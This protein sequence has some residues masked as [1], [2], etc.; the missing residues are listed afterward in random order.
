MGVTNSDKIHA[1]LLQQSYCSSTSARQRE[2]T[3]MLRVL[4]QFLQIFFMEMS[5]SLRCSRLA[6]NCLEP[7][8]HV[9]LPAEV[10][11]KGAISG[12]N[13]SHNHTIVA[14]KI[15]HMRSLLCCERGSEDGRTL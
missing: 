5:V 14:A 3:A 11:V 15:E 12:S 10:V 6:A 8:H 7:P 4:V 1:I 9:L 2:N 13:W